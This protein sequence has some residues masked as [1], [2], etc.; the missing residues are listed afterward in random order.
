MSAMES[1]TINIRRMARS[2]IDTVLT[3]NKET[4]GGQNFISHKDVVAAYIGEALD[5]SFVAEANDRVVGFVLAQLAY[6]YIPI[7][8]VCIIHAIAIAPDYQRSRIGNRLISKL[9]SYCQVKDITTIRALVDAY[10]PELRRF[11][12]RLGFRQSTILNYDK[13]FEN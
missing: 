3:L 5:L 12:E 7:T 11:V 9:L 6:L 1:G 13:T 10:N 2:D 4:S 8:E